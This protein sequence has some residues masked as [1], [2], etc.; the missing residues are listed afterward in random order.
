MKPK[1][2]DK[3]A[4]SK[5]SKPSRS[6]SRKKSDSGNNTES[7]HDTDGENV[8]GKDLSQPEPEEPPFDPDNPDPNVSLLIIKDNFF[9]LLGGRSRSHRGLALGTIWTAL[10][11]EQK[12]NPHYH[13]K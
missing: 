10:E 4:P 12:S 11:F 7:E 6:K 1:A 3:K 5:T 9:S 13:A 2:V 8:T